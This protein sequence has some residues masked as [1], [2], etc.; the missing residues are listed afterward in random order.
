MDKM[1]VTILLRNNGVPL[2]QAHDAT[3][4]IL[5]EETVRVSFPDAIDIRSIRRELKQLGVIL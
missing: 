1:A 3:N 5:R 2:A 4:S